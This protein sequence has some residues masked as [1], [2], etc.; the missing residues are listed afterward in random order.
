LMLDRPRDALA[1]VKR[2][3][4]LDAVDHES[5]FL[6]ARLHKGLGELK[7]YRAAL[8]KGLAVPGLVRE[9]PQLAQQLYYDRGQY[10]ESTE[11]LA[12]AAV[13]YG[14][15]AKILDHPDVILDHG[16]F[17]RESIVAKAAETYE[18]IGDLYRK[19]K[20]FDA[21]VAAYRTAQ[22]RH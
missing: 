4:T 2:V 1:A 19:L 11:A 10:L 15:S 6:A 9:Q 17:V 12:E 20:N 5:W 3:L 22:A 8:D 21:A 14:E 7:E 18:K 16:P 13:A